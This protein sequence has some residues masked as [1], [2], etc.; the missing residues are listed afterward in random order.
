[1][2]TDVVGRAS[3]SLAGLLGVFPDLVECKIPREEKIEENESQ[4]E[5]K[6]LLP[7][8]LEDIVD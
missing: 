3:T 7:N 2:T 6:V 4:D 8:R 1:M 5:M